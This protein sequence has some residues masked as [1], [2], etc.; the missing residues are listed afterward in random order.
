VTPADL[1]RG[2]E[3]EEPETGRRYEVR[4]VTERTVALA[5]PDGF[6]VVERDAVERD[7]E[8]GRLEVV[9]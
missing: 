2:D 6:V 4:G 7:L 3:L 9:R 5:G 1:E 8:S